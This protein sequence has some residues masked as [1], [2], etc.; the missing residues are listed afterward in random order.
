[1][2][3]QHIQKLIVVTLTCVG[4]LFASTLHAA[5]P[6]SFTSLGNSARATGL[7]GAF[8]ALADDVTAAY[9]NP[10]GLT[11]LERPAVSFLHRV[12]TIDTNY[13][14]LTGA[15]PLPDLG[16]FAFGLNYYAVS[17]VGMY[18]TQGQAVGTL[19][20]SEAAAS[21]AYA[22]EFGDLS[23]GTSAQYL[24]QRMTD[25]VVATR[26]GGLTLSA[27]A[28]YRLSEQLR[29]GVRV[30]RKSDLKDLDD[31]N[32]YQVQIPFSI[33]TGVHWKSPWES[34]VVANVTLDLTQRQEYPLFVNLGAEFV[35]WETLALRGGVRDIPV[36]RRGVDVGYDDL[37]H[38]TVKPVIG[39]GIHRSSGHKQRIS[40]DYALSMEQVGIRS[41]ISL[42]YQ[43]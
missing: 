39:M 25:D 7:G 9:W 43:F 37:W 21:L 4:M 13:V 31:A 3:S 22:F 26:T 28:L 6:A 23:L 32:S 15:W 36:E 10:A 29:F 19:E 20:D 17:D 8:V 30:G 16:T 27:A 35:L 2:K 12:T 24:Y 18:D 34:P 38:A 41:F 40:L 14:T 33:T 42:G 5:L 11:Q 1:M